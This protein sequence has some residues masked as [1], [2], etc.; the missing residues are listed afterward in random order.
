[1]T[2]GVSK[3]WTVSFIT[4]K[5][6]QTGK[7]VNDGGFIKLMKENKALLFHDDDTPKRSIGQIHA[8]A[9]QLVAAGIVSF[10]I[11]NTTKVGTDKL[12]NWL[13]RKQQVYDMYGI[14][15]T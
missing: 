9:L 11:R 10:G 3:D 13:Q 1:M 6:P 8:L 7:G 12:N 14:R 2:K 15:H 5:I 4:T